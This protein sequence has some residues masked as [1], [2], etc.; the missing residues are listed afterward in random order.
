[1]RKIDFAI[2][3][4]AL[5][6]MVVWLSSCDK[7]EPAP[8]PELVVSVESLAI[9]KNGAIK[10]FHIKSNIP[11]QLT[12]SESWCVVSPETGAPG[13]VKIDVT[14]PANEVDAPRASTVT[15]TA[16]SLTKQVTITQDAAVILS[17]SETEFTVDSKGETIDVTVQSSADYVVQIS[18][19]W[20]VEAS[21]S[22]SANRVFTIAS[23]PGVITRSGTVTFSLD[24]VTQVVVINQSGN[25]L[26]ISPDN[27]GMERDAMELAQKMKL[28][29][30][31]GN[32][33]EATNVNNGVYTASETLWG[34]P[35]A[36]KTLIDGIKAAGF[37]AVRIPCA[38]NGYIEDNVTYKIRDSWLTRVREVIDYCVDNDMFVIINIHWDGGW[39]EEHPTY[40][41]QEEVNK[42]QK[43]LW[44]QIAVSLRDYD[45]RVLFAGTNEVH[46]NSNPTTENF[47]VQMSYNQTF[48]DAVRST[49]GKN[50]FRNLVVQGYNT[51][52]QLTYDHL[53]LPN[54]ITSNRLMTEIHFY[55]P[56][57][58][59]GLLEDASWATVKYFWGAD[60]AGNPKRSDWGQEAWVDEAFGLMKEKF[61]DKAIPVILGEYGPTLRSNLTG[62]DLTNHLNSRH[63]YLNYVTKAAKENGL[64]PF[65]WDNGFTGNHG[66]GLFNRTTG[67]PVHTEALAAI[68]SAA[69]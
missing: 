31:L 44:E 8:D 29:W 51:N 62:A 68:V 55:D 10:S 66:S 56:W 32:T 46:T 1:M 18:S 54:D 39:L 12:S 45:E 4:F 28:G 69:E 26:N 23:H 7:A 40:E 24:D 36:S 3:L 5:S 11:W 57:D 21:Q 64:V 33:L 60:Y 35:K 9:P 67:E 38:W 6:T 16:G 43:V 30:N 61:I 48:V 49:G 65:Y 37:N 63:Y 2:L 42:K 17:I 19:E 59:C 34:N 22:S 20:I 58:F 14:V 52:I 15:V 41:H 27:S 13:T 50:A 53:V 47:E 25:P